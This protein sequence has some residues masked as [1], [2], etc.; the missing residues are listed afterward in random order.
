V[1]DTYGMDNPQGEKPPGQAPPHCNAILLCESVIRDEFTHKTTIVGIFD[2]FF[3]ASIPGYT[4][5]STV[6][7]RL[8]GVVGIHVVSVEVHGIESRAVLFRSEGPAQFGAPPERTASELRMPIAP[9]AVV[10]P[11]AFHM[12]VFIDGQESGRLSF[13]IKLQPTSEK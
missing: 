3:V 5:P 12:V 13:D 7:V 4:S 2:T 9:L 8:S 10:R 1:R 6:Y 11:G